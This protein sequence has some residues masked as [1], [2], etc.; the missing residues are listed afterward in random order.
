MPFLKDLIDLP[1]QVRQGDFVLRLTEGLGNPEQTLENYVVTPELAKCLRQALDLV[2]S[3]LQS[4]SSKGAYL[5]GSFGSGKSHFMAVLNLMLANHPAVQRFAEFPTLLAETNWNDWGHGKKF[6]LVPFHMIGKTDLTSAILEGY[7]DFVTRLHPDKPHPGV[8]RSEKLLDN[9]RSLRKQMGDAAFFT[10]I[11]S[12]ASSDNSGW[13]VLGTAWD[14]DS[15][16]RAG[17]AH[18]QHPERVRLVGS[19]VATIFSHAHG[20]AEYIDLDNGLS[21]ISS[22]AKSLGYDAIILFLDE[23][24][25]WL[26]S[27]AGK[28][29]F[30]TQQG[31][32]LAKLVESQN[33]KRPVPLISF[34][35]RQKSLRELVGDT[36]L[37]AQYVSLD[38]SIKHFDQRF[39]V[40]KLEDRNLPTI[41]QKRVLKPKNEAARLQIDESFRQTEK[42]R[43]DVLDILQ[44]REGDRTQFRKIYPFSPALMETLVALSTLLQRERTALKIMLMLLVEQKETLE[45]GQIIPV[46]DIFDIIMRGEEPFSDVIRVHFENARRL[47]LQHL[48]PLI[49]GRNGVK[50]EQ[51]DAGS[52]TDPK[53]MGFRRDDRLAK[54]LL[55]SALAPEVESFRA[56]T[57]NKLAALNHGSI[58]TPIPGQEGRVVLQK[59]REWASEIGQIKIGEEEGNP[60]VSVQLAG[61]DTDSLVNQAATEDNGGNRI[62]KVRELVYEMM[63][64]Q[65]AEA[66]WISHDFVWR[67]TKRQCQFLFANVRELNHETLNNRTD[68]WKVI[69]DFPFDKDENHGPRDDL[70]KIESF[71]QQFPKGARTI[72]WM[73]SFLNSSA[74]RELGLLVKLEH[75]LTGSRFE[76]YAARLSAVERAQARVILE[77]QSRALR[78]KLKGYLDAAYG[79]ASD[80]SCLDSAH[81]LDPEEQITSLHPNIALSLPAAATLHD[82]VHEVLQEALKGQYPG[83]PE[84]ATDTRISIASIKRV[85]SELEKGL[86]TADGRSPVEQANRREVKLIAEPL[87]LATMGETHLVVD[88]HWRQHFIPRESGESA[89]TVA[90]LRRWIDEPQ[91]M[92]L[93]LELQ[94]LVILFFATQADRS[95]TLHGGPVQ[96]SMDT[97]R[98]EMEL[99]TQPLPPE[100]QWKEACLRA[101]GIFGLTPGSMYNATNVARLTADLKAKAAEFQSATQSLLVELERRLLERKIS[102]G[103]SDRWVAA[104]AGRNLIEALR[105]A[106]ESQVIAAL[107]VAPA[108]PSALTLGTSIRQAA[109]VHGALQRAK[110]NIIDSATRL[111]DYRQMAA[112]SIDSRARDVL[113]KNEQE[114][115]LPGTL[116]GIEDDAASLLA[117]RPKTP[118]PLPPTPPPPLPLPFVDPTPVAPPAAVPRDPTGTEVTLV[119]GPTNPNKV[120]PPPVEPVPVAQPAWYGSDEAEVAAFYAQEPQLLERNRRLVAVLKSL[121]G[122]SQVDGDQL[123]PGLPKERVIEALEVHHIRPLSQGGPDEWSNMIVVTVSLHALIHADAECR[124]DLQ[125]RTMTLFGVRLPLNIKPDHFG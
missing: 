22:H 61:V 50:K 120:G 82:A 39:D 10:A 77:N 103:S 81:T 51:A 100:T 80:K 96:A 5:H 67:G 29:E 7:T 2:K 78:Q 35:A 33:A 84:F 47:Y 93:P 90:K 14:A 24:I 42:I 94:N 76:T 32:L 8:Y 13:G 3:S 41:A 37:G 124:I 125:Q 59:C 109:A 54:T 97:L 49:E 43:R 83:H 60:T 91:P 95:L 74:Q 87:K 107:A 28:P 11:N 4:H 56:M 89:T 18:P 58:K 115:A 70:S 105:T 6:L 52:A 104:H 46:G 98:D 122:T 92:G 64:L 66:L 1:D 121:Y 75:V 72:A 85:W 65:Q 36:M 73:P 119:V 31:Q 113:T 111:T 110:W 116:S 112:E 79:L 68:D 27:H 71:R 114:I 48:L 57:V 38:D 102:P 118:T 9:A 21:V 53:V 106:P 99:R 45:L 117:D 34:I 20:T 62:R 86:Q 19:L 88:A 44:T 17:N 108:M 63:G 23:L 16:D 55:L 40:I 15:F 12:D 69:I 101:Q 30:V 26:A 25:L 123:P